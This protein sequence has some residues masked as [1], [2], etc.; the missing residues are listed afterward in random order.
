MQ[1]FSKIRTAIKDDIP[2]IVKLEQSDK[3]PYIGESTVHEH[4][5]NLYNDDY[6]YLVALD[7][8]GKATGY[9]I[10]EETSADKVLLLRLAVQSP[11]QGFGKPFIA[12]VLAYMKRNSE[13]KTIWLDVFEANVGAKRV[14][15]SFGFT[16][17]GTI[18]APYGTPMHFGNSILMERGL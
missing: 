17:T 13:Y 16:E 7:T 5:G 15:D 3:H 9:A 14:Y 6:I 1:K 12:E 2:L 11:G 8:R 10:L 4:A 18:A